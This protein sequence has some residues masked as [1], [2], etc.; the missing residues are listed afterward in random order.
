MP[1]SA[2]LR[3]LHTGASVPVQFRVTGITLQLVFIWTKYAVD[4]S[5]RRQTTSSKRRLPVAWKKG[6]RLQSDDRR[7]K[8]HGTP[9]DCPAFFGHFYRKVS[10]EIAIF[11][12]AE[13]ISS[14]TSS[15]VFSSSAS[16]SGTATRL[17]LPA[18]WRRRCPETHPVKFTLLKSGGNAKVFNR[19]LGS[20]SGIR[21]FKASH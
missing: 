5:A 21:S 2:A 19:M 13:A 17:P 3:S 11:A 4:I 18:I 7:S 12:L 6:L 15:A 14:I 10:I 9:P 1:G 16:G 8:V 20:A